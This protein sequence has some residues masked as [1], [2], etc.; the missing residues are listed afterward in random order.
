MGEG[1][2]VSVRHLDSAEHA[3]RDE[4]QHV[5]RPE[6]HL[7]AKQ[8]DGRAEPRPPS[9]AAIAAP[10]IVPW[11]ANVPVVP[12]GRVVGRHRLRQR[13]RRCVWAQR[14]SAAVGARR[15]ANLRV[16]A[17]VARARAMR[18]PAKFRDIQPTS[19][20]P[21]LFLYPVLVLN[22]LEH[23]DGLVRTTT[24]PV[25]RCGVSQRRRSKNH[26]AVRPLGAPVEARGGVELLAA[27]GAALVHAAHAHVAERVPARVDEHVDLGLGLGLGLGVEG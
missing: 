7:R 5:L 24:T 27:E 14:G 9:R 25:S 12:V 4:A 19:S 13:G 20:S 18:D 1:L 3:D 21:V 6:R 10:I 26:P 2:R 8:R 22:T 23:G 17:G 16:H 15:A 11:S